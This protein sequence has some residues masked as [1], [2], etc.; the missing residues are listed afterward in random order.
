MKIELQKCALTD[1]PKWL[2]LQIETYSPLL[3]KY[4][5]YEIS[6]ATETLERVIERM[7]GPSREY[8]FILK[9]GEIVGGVRTAW[10]I[11]TTRYRLGGI[12]VLPQFQNSGVGQIAINLAE[13]RYPDATTWELDTVLQERRNLHF[14]EKLG[15]RREGGEQAVN[16]KMSLVFYKKYLQ[17]KT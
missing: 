10:W 16:D 9:D 14:Y 5:D 7:E 1:A 8:F 17:K 2:E 15:Y 4:Q 12:F 3:E 6:P 13:A 11:N